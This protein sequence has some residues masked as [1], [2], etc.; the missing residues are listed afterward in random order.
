MAT[1]I[2]E[3][4]DL[5]YRKKDLQMTTQLSKQL[6]LAGSALLSAL[7]NRERRNGIGEAI[8]GWLEDACPAWGMLLG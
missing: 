6:M 8:Q 1:A 7:A 5:A 2:L 3:K 4:K